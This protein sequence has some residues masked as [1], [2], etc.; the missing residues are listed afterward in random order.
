MEQESVYSHLN[1]I[2]INLALWFLIS[3]AIWLLIFFSSGELIS[4]GIFGILLLAIVSFYFGYS[5]GKMRSRKKILLV[6]SLLFGLIYWMLPAMYLISLWGKPVHPTDYI[7][8]ATPMGEEGGRFLVTIVIL[9]L[10]FI[11]LII[12]V[13][14]SLVGS[15]IGSKRKN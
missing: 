6:D 8:G 4:L 9:A 2:K 14:F 7:G 5:G 13:F 3:S 10:V 12:G 11:S 15:Y 1:K